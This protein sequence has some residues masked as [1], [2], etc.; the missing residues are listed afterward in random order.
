[1][2]AP[3]VAVARQVS[4]HTHGGRDFH[5]LRYT[6]SGGANHA[7]LSDSKIFL[8]RALPLE[9]GAEERVGVFQGVCSPV[10]LAE[11]PADDPGET[12]EP[13]FCRAATVDLL[14]RSSELMTLAQNRIESQIDVLLDA[15]DRL[16]TLGTTTNIT[17]TAGA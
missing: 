2:P 1:M 10:D 13:P 5:R 6:A 12:A 14:F 17:F 9:T 8:Y 11:M 4:K 7:L 16:T 3:T 15:L